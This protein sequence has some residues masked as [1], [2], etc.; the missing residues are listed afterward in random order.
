MNNYLEHDFIYQ[1]II[2]DVKLYI[3]KKCK[4]KTYAYTKDNYT[5]LW[6]YHE[7]YEFEKIKYTCNE[8]IIKNIIE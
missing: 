4:L 7:T 3:C 1:D 6:S 5:Q 2:L 8:M